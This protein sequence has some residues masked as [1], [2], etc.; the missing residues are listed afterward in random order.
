MRVVRSPPPEPL[1]FAKFPNALIGPDA[2]IV[3]PVYAAAELDYEVEMVLVVGAR[4]Y[5]V[6]ES[7]ALT[8]LGGVTVGND[9]ASRRVTDSC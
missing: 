9:G 7:A 2:D 8:H 4:A 5:Q 6:P 1:V 3:C